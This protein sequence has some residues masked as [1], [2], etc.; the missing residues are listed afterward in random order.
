M[1][2]RAPVGVSELTLSRRPLVLVDQSTEDLAPT[3]LRKRRRTRWVTTHRRDGRPK[4]EAAVRAVLVVVLDVAA[5]D[6][7]KVLAADDQ[8]VVQALSADGPDP[9][10][11]DGVGVGRPNRRAD[12]LGTG[13]APHIIERPGE[14]GVPVPD[15]EPERGGTVAAAR[16]CRR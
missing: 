4:A 9:A 6:V 10:F 16:R 3:Q 14:L 11:G 8:E 5:Q 15:Q 1:G 12:D 13:R 2:W 7:N